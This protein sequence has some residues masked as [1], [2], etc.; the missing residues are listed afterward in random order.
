MQENK[1]TICKSQERKADCPFCE[2]NRKSDA[3][4][5]GRCGKQLKENPVIKNYKIED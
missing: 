2:A 4:F 5:C 1:K 3:N